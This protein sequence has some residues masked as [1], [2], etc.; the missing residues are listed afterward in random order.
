MFIFRAIGAAIRIA[1]AKLHQPKLSIAEID[2]AI[3]H[4]AAARG[5][6]DLDWRNSIVDLLKVLD[7]DP[8]FEH[9][10]HLWGE[11]GFKDAYTGSA[12]QNTML[13]QEVRKRFADGQLD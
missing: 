1:F 8:S 2:A 7:I 12:V 9:R 4:D 5:L 10:N 13:I 3:E 6:S 11:M